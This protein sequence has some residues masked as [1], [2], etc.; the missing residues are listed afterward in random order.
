MTAL[1]KLQDLII[2]G[3]SSRNV[4]KTGLA[5]TLIEKL[6]M[7]G[8]VTGLKVTSLR[9]GEEA[10][11]GSH[12]TNQNSKFRITEEKDPFTSKDT[13]RMLK[14]GAE[15]VFF[16]ESPDN[17]LE[18]AFSVFMKEHYSGGPVVCESRSLRHAIVP[19]L[20]IL[21]KHY[22]TDLIKDDFAYYE[23]QADIIFTIDRQIINS[24]SLAHKITWDA[25]GWK[26]DL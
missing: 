14:A 5:L 17:L 19:G 8:K 25:C 6:S 15:K 21:L 13:S 20:F 26:S 12:D 7:H 3:G 9:P 24:N 16:I 22:N 18:S 23:K 2:I 10:F 1:K 11:H 4:G